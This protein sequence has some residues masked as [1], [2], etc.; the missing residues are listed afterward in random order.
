MYKRQVLST[1][2]EVFVGR[3]NKENE[4]LTLH[5]ARPWDWFFHARG[6]GGS[7]LILRS[8]TREY[9]PSKREIEEAAK[10][11][12]YFSRARHSSLVPVQYTQRRYIRKPKGSGVGMVV[13]LREEVVFVEPFLPSRS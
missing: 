13:L 2:V 9:K 4:E 3:N 12:A 5:F 10:I 11:A 1:G 8:P 6:A 7:H